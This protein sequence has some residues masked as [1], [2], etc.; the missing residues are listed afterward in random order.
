MHAG[1]Y[2]VLNGKYPKN[3]RSMVATV[4]KAETNGEAQVKAMA[5][6]IRA[7]GFGA[8]ADEMEV[9]AK[10]EGHHGVLMTEILEKYLPAEAEA[11]A[12]PDRKVYVCPVCGYEYE[13]D[14][15]GESDDWTCPL[16]G[17]PKSVFK[18]KA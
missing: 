14:L 10:Q 16:C 15:D 1:F 13:G 2:A 11:E 5:D 6:K 18:L 4:R 9:F 12:V 17:Q 8:A 7:A 3:F